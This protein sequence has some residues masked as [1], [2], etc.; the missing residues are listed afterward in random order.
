MA[1]LLKAQPAWRVFIVGHTDNVGSYDANQALSQQRAQTVVA[2]LATAP[3]A[4][5]PKR[6]VAKGVANIAPV[7]SNGDDAGRAR[8]RR[9]EM[10]LQ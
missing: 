8:N 10:V 3:Y 1:A 2:A 5:D 4:I 7:A 6:L 9:V